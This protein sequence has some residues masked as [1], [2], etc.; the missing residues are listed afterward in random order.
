MGDRESLVE[1]GAAAMNEAGTDRDATATDPWSRVQ[2]VFA[3]PSNAMVRLASGCSTIAV[4]AIR[5]CAARWSRC[6]RHTKRQVPSTGSLLPSRPRR[7][8]YAR[9]LRGGKDARSD[10]IA[11][12]SWLTPAAW[13]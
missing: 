10:T 12:A 8:G 13:A 2:D 4:R 11:L 1:P 9:R 5:R 6:S 7:C 3:E